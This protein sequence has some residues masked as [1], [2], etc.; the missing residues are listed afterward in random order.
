MLCYAKNFRTLIVHLLLLFVWADKEQCG[1]WIH[2]QS[3]TIITRTDDYNFSKT[4]N[5][6]VSGTQNESLVVSGHT[7]ISW[8][9]SL[10][11]AVSFPGTMHGR[12]QTPIVPRFG[13]IWRSQ[14]W[15]IS[16][17]D[18]PDLAR[19]PTI[20]RKRI[21]PARPRRPAVLQFLNVWD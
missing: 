9:P 6:S 2:D 16:G 12:R 18:F 14:S 15:T 3:K 20:F 5:T 10:N 7:S 21:P 4:N 11:E 19:P 1:M 13:K 8:S 17:S